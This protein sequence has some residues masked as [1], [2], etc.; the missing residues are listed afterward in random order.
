MRAWLRLTSLFGLPDEAG[1][2][3]HLVID[4]LGPILRADGQQIMEAPLP[5]QFRELL[6]Q[7]ARGER[8]GRRRRQAMLRRRRGRD[9]GLN[10]PVVP[11]SAPN[12]GSPPVDTI[13]AAI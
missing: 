1:Q 5:A 10:T 2:I 12:H 6:D 4:A 7:L 9:A 11:T 8:N 3:D 13:T